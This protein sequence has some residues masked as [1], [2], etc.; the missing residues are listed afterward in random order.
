MRYQ[1]KLWVN[2]RERKEKERERE[3]FPVK[4]SNLRQ[5]LVCSQNKGLSTYQK[6]AIQLQNRPISL[7]EAVR[8]VVT[9]R[10]GTQG[11]ISAPETYPPPNCEQTPSC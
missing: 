10:A 4:S 11:A 6:R 1:F 9:A 7:S 5:S 8:Q 2:Q 3:N